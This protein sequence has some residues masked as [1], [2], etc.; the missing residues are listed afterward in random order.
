MNKNNIINYYE[1]ILVHVNVFDY[2]LLLHIYK[3][4]YKVRI[5]C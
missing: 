5:C 4:K 2:F 3:W 1:I